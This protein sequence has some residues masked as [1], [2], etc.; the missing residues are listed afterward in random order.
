[1]RKTAEER[2]RDDQELLADLA[3]RAESAQTLEFARK[4]LAGLM[5]MGLDPENTRL[6]SRLAGAYESQTV[7]YLQSSA[8]CPQEG[9]FML[10]AILETGAA[11]EAGCQPGGLTPLMHAVSASSHEAALALAEAGADWNW[12][13]RRGLFAREPG[14]GQSP[15]ERILGAAPIRSPMGNKE[16]AVKRWE[17]LCSMAIDA[18]GSPKLAE[19]G[20]AAL[21]MGDC[22]SSPASRRLMG[23][24]KEAGA[25]GAQRVEKC[26]HTGWQGSGASPA[27]LAAHVAG[28]GE[29]DR[30]NDLLAIFPK[31]S[32]PESM[33]GLLAAL[34]M[35]WI[36]AAGEGGFTEEERWMGAEE[37]KSLASKLAKSSP[38]ERLDL[39]AG[40][41]GPSFANALGAL[42]RDWACAKEVFEEASVFWGAWLSSSQAAGEGLDADAVA[43][44]IARGA[45]GLAPLELAHRQDRVWPDAKELLASKARG[46]GLLAADP[47]LAE[48]TARFCDAFALEW[49]MAASESGPR[50][51]GSGGKKKAFVVFL[52]ALC[53]EL[54]AFE[55]ADLESR[56]KAWEGV[57]EGATK[58]ALGLSGAPLARMERVAALAASGQASSRPEG[59]AK[60]RAKARI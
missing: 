48:Q 21:V 52:E 16:Q 50:G 51:K 39:K 17:R 30:L 25:S 55:P 9:A 11:P 46:L 1:M 42:C 40:A 22:E 38:L 18:L 58:A 43:R 37:A 7:N 57:C 26:S 28:Q 6:P 56:A 31:A 33:R 13:S 36:N 15:A 4:A 49:A 14:V 45:G 27:W 53:D 19:A 34:G 24:L 47:R 5:A 2:A 3:Q 44:E 32:E 10:R 8:I 60:P 23:K 54:N 29:A 59:R 41:L 35:G 20:L 12:R